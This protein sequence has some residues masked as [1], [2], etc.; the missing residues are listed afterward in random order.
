MSIV[1]IEYLF[2]IAVLF[3]AYWNISA[4]FQWILL[5]AAS[6]IFYVFNAPMYTLIY[7]KFY[8]ILYTFLRWYL[9][10]YLDTVILG[11]YC[12]RNIDLIMIG[13]SQ[14]LKE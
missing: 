13:L 8:Y 5:L 14:G 7:I 11:R 9:V 3:I 4:K 6:I 12:L 10:R 1:S 2:F